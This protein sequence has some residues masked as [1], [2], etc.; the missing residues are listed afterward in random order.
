MQT[1]E[2]RDWPSTSSQHRSDLGLC[3]Q[4]PP[5]YSLPVVKLRAIR[6]QSYKGYLYGLLLL[7]LLLIKYHK[8]ERGQSSRQEMWLRQVETVQEFGGC[9]QL[10]VW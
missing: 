3:A 4:P 9:G 6:V 2:C 10:D 7:F 1:P 5:V 8:W